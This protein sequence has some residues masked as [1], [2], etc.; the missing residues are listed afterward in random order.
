M[1]DSFTPNDIYEMFPELKEREDER[2]REVLV[3]YFK[4]YK[5]QEGCGIKT[6]FG[7]PTDN[8]ITWLE[9]QGEKKSIEWSGK[10]G[11]KHADG[12][13]KEMLDRK[14]HH[15]WS[16]ED[17]LHIR[18]LE[19][20]VKQVWVTAEHENEKDTIHKMS[21]LSFFLKTLKPQPK[22]EWSVE[23]MSKIQRICKYLD[24]AKKYYADITEVRECV[25]WLNSLKDRSAWKPSDAQMIVL[26]EIITNGHLSNANERILKGLQEQLK[27]LK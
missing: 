5:E 8:I 14:E 18:E 3:D 21:D 13:L 19:S 17:E 9:K 11:V 26:N 10:I 12:K 23:D 1:V 6:F 15:A 25:D 16:E 27:K 2:I 20:L 4:R 7:I 24:E 22:Q